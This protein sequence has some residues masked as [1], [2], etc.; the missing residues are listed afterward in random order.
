MYK[1]EVEDIVLLLSI[2]ATCLSCEDSARQS[3]AMVPT[4]RFFASFLC[5]AFPASPVQQ[6]S[7]M[8]SKFTLRPQIRI[9]MS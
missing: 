7:D 5:P 8:N 3:C 9:Q 2:V 1:S 4:W 6:V